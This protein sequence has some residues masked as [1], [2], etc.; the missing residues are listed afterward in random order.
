MISFFGVFGVCV[1]VF[2]Q[3]ITSFLPQKLFSKNFYRCF[4]VFASLGGCF[5]LHF[6]FLTN[7]FSSESQ[8]FLSVKVSRKSIKSLFDISVFFIHALLNHLWWSIF[9]VTPKFYSFKKI[10]P[11]LFS[12]TDTK[13]NCFD[14]L[15]QTVS[16]PP[17]NNPENF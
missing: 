11:R 3:I 4:L 15:K 8:F 2:F 1:C 16:K 14:Y 13:K 17:T 5:P 7:F 9:E 6:G 12:V 10:L